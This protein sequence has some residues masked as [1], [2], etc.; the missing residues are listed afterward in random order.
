MR[1]SDDHLAATSGRVVWQRYRADLACLT[2]LL[3]LAIVAAIAWMPYSLYRLDNLTFY[4]PW[5]EH[6]GK[7]LRSFD[8]PG[9]LPNVFSGA[10][11]AGDPQS[12]WGYLPAMTIMTAI[13][14]V[15]GFKIFLT[16]HIVLAALGSYLYIRNLGMV[17]IA[18]FAGA[19][20]F[21]FGNF[22]ERTSCCT[23]HMQVIVWIP[24]VFL[25]IDRIIQTDDKQMRWIYAFCGGLAVSQMVAGWIGQGAYYAGLATAI[26]VIYR[27]VGLALQRERTQWLR[28]G[29]AGLFAAFV[30]F[31][32]LAT[33]VLPR[34]SVISR[35][36]LAT[37][38]DEGAGST[39]NAGW[40]SWQFF[41][42]LTGEM[43]R[44]GRWYLGM[45]GLAV[46]LIAWPL[47]GRRKDVPFFT[48]YSLGILA[49][50]Q[51]G[52]PVRWPFNLLPDFASIHSHSPDRILIVFFIGPAVLCAAIL[53]ALLDRQWRPPP[54]P[55]IVLALSLP[56]LLA[57]LG[58]LW[59]AHSSGDSVPHNRIVFVALACLGIGLGLVRSRPMVVRIGIVIVILVALYDP[60]VRLLI[61]HHNQSEVRESA[62]AITDANLDPTEAAEW[63]QAKSA[64]D[65]P[66]RFFGYDLG[67]TLL[68]G[69]R[70]TYASAHYNLETS[71]ILVNNRSVRLGLEDIQG[72]NPVQLRR[73]VSFIATMNG[74]DQSYHMASV[75]PGGI[76]SPLLDLLGVRY[77]VVPLAVPTNR[78]DLLHLSIRY[79]DCFPGR[80]GAHFGEYPG[81]ASCL[82][83]PFR[84]ASGTA[85]DSAN[86]SAE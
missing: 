45:A 9:W 80:S 33:A 86:V 53:D 31:C 19:C 17:P 65:G 16:F 40:R 51:R 46:I 20:V 3:V 37:L 52:S 58:P 26:Y 7:S 70:D 81:V 74:E 49:M 12:G 56:I 1:H 55:R 4:L 82:G 57:V 54:L 23:I 84:E 66:F 22:M 21:T 5:Y 71:R 14:S 28:I 11:F 47:L 76:T 41:D 62:A 10:P 69:D 6:L 24:I 77:I 25:L 48:L 60:T 35:S 43:T 63:L 79:P 2:G 85:R 13:P 34:L 36:N 75:L 83:C 78:P 73:Y 32:F 39:S 30:A 42:R 61:V 18:S 67:L 15:T 29:L 68:D 8:I 64:E 27:V 44:N 72:Y 38:Y 50:I 59:V